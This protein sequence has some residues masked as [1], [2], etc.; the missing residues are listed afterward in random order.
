MNTKTGEFYASREEA[1]AA[2]TNPNDVIEVKV[3]PEP[4]KPPKLERQQVKE[5]VNPRMT[6]QQRSA[7]DR[8][9]AKNRIARKSRKKNR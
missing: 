4:F 2:G 7:K 8:N 3:K 1:I 9:R 6:A 5:W